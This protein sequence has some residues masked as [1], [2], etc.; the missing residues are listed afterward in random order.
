[1]TTAVGEDR[2]PAPAHVARRQAP[3]WVGSVIGIAALIG[4]WW[5]LAATV[6]SGGKAVPT[7][8]A[9]VR[10]IVKDGWHFYGPNLR[11]TV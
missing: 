11:A 8:A 10:Q 2:L 6:L 1:M 9:V 5:L 7:P 3:G 4:L